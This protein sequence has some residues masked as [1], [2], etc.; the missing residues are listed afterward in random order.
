MPNISFGERKSNIVIEERTL[1]AS[2]S[3]KIDNAVLSLCSSSALVIS[4]M[5]GKAVGNHLRLKQRR[6]LVLAVGSVLFF[7]SDFMLLLD[8]FA[9]APRIAIWL[10]L[11][12]YYPAQCLLAAAPA[13]DH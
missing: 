7:L 12:F 5:V 13:F 8:I 2:I 6:T 1:I 11:L 3:P 10:C 9:D 4:L